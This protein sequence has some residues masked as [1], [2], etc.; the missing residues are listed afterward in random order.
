[1]IQTAPSPSQ[2]QVDAA[3]IYY[4]GDY[5]SQHFGVYPENFDGVTVFQGLAHDIARYVELAG[6]HGGPILEIGCGTGRV[7]MPLASAGHQVTGVDLSAAQLAQ[8]R[9]NLS[10]AG[11]GLDARVQLVEQDATRLDLG[12]QRFQMA[13]VAFNSLCCIPDFGGQQ[14]ALRGIAAHLTPGGV[15]VLD[16]VNPLRLKIEGDPVPK[17]FFT[18]RNPHNGNSYTR[19]AMVG[20]FDAEHRQ[21][22][23]G[24]YDEIDADGHVVRRPYDLTWRPIFRHE[25]ALMLDAAGFE[26]RSVEGGHQGEAYTAQSPRM[27]IQARR[28]SL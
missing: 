21:R 7:A 28:R 15:L 11:Q 13:I 22:L 27:V 9:A 6:Q 1:M 25:I 3:T 16:I 2:P 24:W 26:I 23:H 10:R 8:F 18:R 20:P 4:D 12:G 17:P 19:F 5:P 14:Q